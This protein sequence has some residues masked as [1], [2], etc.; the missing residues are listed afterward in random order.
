M[1]DCLVA[2]PPATALGQTLFAKSS[3]RPPTEAQALEWLPARRDSEP[4]IC[5]HISV[6]PSR[7]ETLG[8]LG[9]RPRWGW[10]LEA[11]VNDASVA[12]G[13]EAIYT[14]L[15]PRTAAPALTGM[16]LVR[17]ALERGATA[18][19]AVE[20][21]T[22]LLERYGQGGTGHMGVERPYWSSFLVADPTRAWVVETSGRTWAADEIVRTRAISNRTSIPAFD[23][24]H[25]HPSQLVATLVDPRLRASEAVL[26]ST[27]VTTSGLLGHLR[28]HAGH[29]GWTICMHADDDRHPERTT[30]SLVAS[31]PRSGPAKCWVTLGSPCRSI[32]VPV[33]VGE[34]LGAVPPW[35]RFAA[36][37]DP[38]ARPDVRAALDACQAMLDSDLPPA[39]D[40]WRIVREV[41]DEIDAAAAS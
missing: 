20:V 24:V 31:L 35:E 26:A 2:L 12:V 13:N 40:A 19:E 6:T 17:L 15:D 25:R 39:A 22:T 30:A 10:G 27:P 33:T 14:T 28:S 18:G 36:L 29:G 38:A 5:T 16:D 23:A 8:I 7:V 4:F 3:D 11:G 37:P 21:I 32:A 9:L 1:C 41:L 34:P